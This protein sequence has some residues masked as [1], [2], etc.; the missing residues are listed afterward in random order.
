MPGRRDPLFADW[1]HVAG[2][3]VIIGFG[4]TVLFAWLVSLVA[5]SLERYRR[6]LLFVFLSMLVTTSLVS[7]LKSVSSIYC[8]WDLAR[9]GGDILEA[10]SI[11]HGWASGRCFPSGHASA[12]Y[13]L[14]AL[15]FFARVYSPRWRWWVFGFA[16]GMGL[17]FGIT[18]Q[19]RGAHF[20]SH[21]LWAASLSWTL[22]YLLARRMFDTVW[23]EQFRAKGATR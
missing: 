1:L 22:S 17:L 21:D 6:G 13:A 12:G 23:L 4:L 14:F 9:Y 15:F 2:R 3:R 5:P 10:L 19:L 11:Q 16:L 18:Q 8:P 7:L 20:V